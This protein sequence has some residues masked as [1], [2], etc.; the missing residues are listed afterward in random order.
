MSIR[1][2][3]RGTHGAWM[4]TG[5]FLRAVTRPFFNRELKRLEDPNATSQKLFMGFPVGVVTTI[6][7]K[8]G[9]EHKHVLG[10]F[11]EGDNAWLLIA[12]NGGAQAH[13]HWFINIAKNPDKVWL[14]VANKRFRV[15]VESLQGKERDDAYERVAA[16]G[17][18]YRSYPKKTDR[19]I[20]VLRLT[21]AAE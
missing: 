17:R 3:P 2:P 11:P 13:P 6:G 18:T 9:N 16:V 20:P 7:S 14:Q 21:P 5:R 12:S 15:N 10:V 8:T 1:I 19:E 4:P